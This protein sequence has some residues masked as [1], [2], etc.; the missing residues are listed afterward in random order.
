MTALAVDGQRRWNAAPRGWRCFVLGLRWFNFQVAD[1]VQ[2]NRLEPPI[3]SR[4][5]IPRYR[6]PDPKLVFAVGALSYP[7]E[8]FPGFASGPATHLQGVVRPQ[9]L[10]HGD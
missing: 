2:F 9:N 3:R 7:N 10:V 5:R 1:F 6:T 8:K 4:R